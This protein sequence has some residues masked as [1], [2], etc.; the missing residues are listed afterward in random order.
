M[1]AFWKH[2]EAARDDIRHKLVEEAWFGRQV[3]GDAATQTEA[4]ATPAATTAVK[5]ESRHPLYEQ[6]WGK[7]ATHAEIYG[8]MPATGQGNETAATQEPTPQQNQGHGPE[9]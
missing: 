4:E 2:F 9:L 1:S 7:A 5:S 3:T 6:T 8:Q